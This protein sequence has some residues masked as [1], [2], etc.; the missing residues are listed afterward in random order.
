MKHFFAEFFGTFGLVF[1]GCGIAVFAASY[2][3]LDIVDL[4]A[5]AF[6]LSFLTM[7]FAVVHISGAHFNPAVSI[8]L[9]AAGRF[10][11]RKIPGYVTAQVLGTCSAAATFFLIFIE[12]SDFKTIGSFASNGYGAL[13]LGN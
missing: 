7:A 1:R 11:S 8:G 10:E 13:S 3:D 12:K 5:L 2:P 6:G 9:W 4:Q